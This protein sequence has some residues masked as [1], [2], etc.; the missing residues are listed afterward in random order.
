MNDYDKN[1]LE[2]EYEEKIA[3]G[4]AW[5]LICVINLMI[6]LIAIAAHVVWSNNITLFLVLAI[7]IVQI[8]PLLAL[9]IS[10]YNTYRVSMEL[11]EMGDSD[12]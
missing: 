9:V 1:K 8:P 3:L 12:G 11:K 6:F 5:L 4:S 2:L 10:L 7:G